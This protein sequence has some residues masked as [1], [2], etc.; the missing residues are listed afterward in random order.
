MFALIKH[1]RTGQYLWISEFG[2]W[3]DKLC[4]FIKWVKN[5]GDME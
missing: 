1:N 4:T 3:N 5:K 2:G